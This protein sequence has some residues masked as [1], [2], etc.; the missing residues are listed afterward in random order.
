M[1]AKRLSSAAIA[2][3]AASL[4]FSGFPHTVSS[5][6]VKGRRGNPGG[7]HESYFAEGTTRAGFRE[8][9]CVGNPG[10]AE[11]TVDAE[12]FSGSGD[13]VDTELKVPALSRATVEVAALVG[14]G[15]DVSVRLSSESPFIAERP[16]YLDGE[17][18]GGSSCAEGATAPSGRWYF[19]EGYTG[20]GFREYLCLANPGGLAADIEVCFSTF[21]GEAKL[22]RV[23][24]PPRSRSTVDVLREVGSD[25]EVSA[26]VRSTNGVPF[27]AERSV[28]FAT[29]RYSGGHC[30]AGIPVPARRF[31]LAEGT[32]R[33]GFQTYVCLYNPGA[34]P[35]E[36]KARLLIDGGKEQDTSTTVPARARRTIDVNAAVGAGHDVSMELTG[37]GDFCAERAV[38]FTS[39]GIADGHCSQGAANRSRRWAFAE[40]TTRAGFKPF[41]CIENPQVEDVRVDVTFYT[42][43][44][45]VPITLNVKSRSR[46]TVDPLCHVGAGNDF[47]CIVYASRPVV[48]ER[49]QYSSTIDLKGGHC[50]PGDADWERERCK[51]VRAYLNTY[52]E[53]SDS[54][55]G[56]FGR[57]DVAVLDP[58][59][60]PDDEFPASLMS[61]GTLL[62]AYI[63]IGE[64]ED[65]RAYWPEIE[66][67]PGVI[68]APNP[69]W[70][71]CYYA[72]VNNPEWRHII[73]E[74]EIPYLES[75][76]P[77][78]GLC[79]DMLDTVDAYPELKAG[80]VE[81]VREIR[82]WH[83][84]LILVPNRGFAI[85]D[86]IIPYVDAFKY[87][88]MS[89]R[90]DFDTGKYV[91][92]SDEEELRTLESALRKKDIPVF[93]LD[94]VQTCPPDNAMAE[95]CFERAQA[96]GAQTG[97]HF[98]W[99]ANSVEQDHPYW[100]WL[101]YR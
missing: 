82:E 23:V 45:A 6:D 9:L 86:D 67:H 40:G 85:L 42:G 39:W 38:Y 46:A 29:D 30:S 18:G 14:P 53:Y 60:Y 51:D 41:V 63:D 91:L 73:V 96:I 47:S 93:V 77:M 74:H 36:L 79:M 99:Y 22:L 44:D 13:P 4:L 15:K 80:M 70:P 35:V 57:F 100:P 94:H 19:A 68:L 62:L 54:D 2:F 95:A 33:D 5:R 56:P 72:D 90:Y 88:E 49:V 10:E 66:K 8:Y 34:R 65:S 59:D 43:G 1:K 55:I 37:N 16:M 64:V 87:E 98:T 48:A 20:A 28:Y 83:P 52:G 11:I 92:A 69:D 101:D 97:G 25:K 32:T 75:L 58:Y 61:T 78:D 84:E 24:V 71:G 12:C 3:L 31:D 89:S 7:L 81:L 27:V 21:A 26:A 50:A 76:G 17:R